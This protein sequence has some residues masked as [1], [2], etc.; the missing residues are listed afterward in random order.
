MQSPPNDETNVM[1]E[2][3]LS[4]EPLIVRIGIAPMADAACRTAAILFDA[5]THE[6]LDELALEQKKAD[7]QRAGC[8]QRCRTDDR[9]VD[10]LIG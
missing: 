4:Q 10:P 5:R 1:G 2:S 8:H 3:G 9:P 6:A 7:Q